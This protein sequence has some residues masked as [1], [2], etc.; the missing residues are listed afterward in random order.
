LTFARVP[1]ILLWLAFAVAQEFLGGFWLGTAACLAMLLSGLTD[2]WDGRLAR[3]WGVVS[4]L[5]KMADPLMDKIFYL[6]AFPALVWQAAHQSG[7][8]LHA[9]ALLVFAILYLLRDTWVT[10]L[11]SVGALYGAD[12]AAMWLGKVRTALSFPGAGW[13]YIYLAFH[14]F[15][16]A[17]WQA[18]WRW[19]CYAVEA[20]LGFLTV[21]SLWTYTRAYL[22]SLKRALSV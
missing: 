14:S 19:S 2:L 9:M 12:L 17:S 7:E 10:F 8:T 11:R 4:T 13:I 22:P 6:V 21:V 18:P 20:F 5:G 15:A 3:K 1:F 16:P